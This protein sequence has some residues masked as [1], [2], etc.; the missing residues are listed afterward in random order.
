VSIGTLEFGARRE[1]LNGRSHVVPTRI[2]NCAHGLE[3]GVVTDVT[4]VRECE[5]KSGSD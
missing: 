4:P 5:L 3:F 2:A 1:V